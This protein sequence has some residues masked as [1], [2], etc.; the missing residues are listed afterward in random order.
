MNGIRNMRHASEISSRASISRVSTSSRLRERVAPPRRDNGLGRESRD[1]GRAAPATRRPFRDLL[2]ANRQ[3]WLE[4]P[5]ELINGAAEGGFG[6]FVELA[7]GADG[8][9]DVRVFVGYEGQQ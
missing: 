6:G 9:G 3:L 5:F 8:F 4:L 7:G 2:S 1:N